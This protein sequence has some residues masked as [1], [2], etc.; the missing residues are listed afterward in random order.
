MVYVRTIR[1]ACV[2]DARRLAAI[3]EQTFRDT[4]ATA[5]TPEDMELHCRES[6]GEA[7][8]AGEIA[9]PEKV[10]LLCEQD[11]KLVG[12]AQLRWGAPPSC[13]VAEAPGEIQ[14]LYVARE[15]HGHGVAHE[16]M[17][18]CIDAM[19]ARRSDVVWLGVWE[20]NPR[21]IAFYEKFG[22]RAVGEH[23]FPVGTDPQRDIVMARRMAERGPAR[24]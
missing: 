20:R 8:Q 11:G 4:F 22:F 1:R 9:D 17:Q 15:F 21:A 18:A 2:H 13:V 7:I 23:V 24:R 14:R 3:A 19:T 10:T 12:F 16:L 5:N 6:Y